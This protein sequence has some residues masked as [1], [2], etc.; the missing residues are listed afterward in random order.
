[1]LV[2]FWT[3]NCANCVRTQPYLNVWYNHY[4]AVGLEI[5]GVHTPE[6]TLERVP[7][8]VEKVM[9]NVGIKYPVALNNDFATWRVYR[10]RYRPMRYL[11]DKDGDVRWTHF[12]E[13]SY[14]EAEKQVRDLLGGTGDK[15]E[16]TGEI[17]QP[18]RGQSSETYP[19]IRRAPGDETRLEAGE[20]DYGQNP[21][22]GIIDRRSLSRNWA[23]DDESVT[24]AWDGAQL[25]YCL[26][27]REMFLMMGGPIGAEVRVQV[28]SSGPPGGVD[29][30]SGEMTI[31]GARL[32]QL[33]QPFEATRGAIITL[34]FDKGVSASTFTFE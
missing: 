9:R 29:V 3:Y 16:V 25:N 13:D 11:T 18:T 12:G 28:G 14:D 27:G 31:F 6:F 21:A 30:Q 19:D 7:E 26:V 17:T 23:T 10:N 1:M 2:D 4:R 32:Y 5:I 24:A 15:A 8:N 20:C 34:T 22:P 33:V